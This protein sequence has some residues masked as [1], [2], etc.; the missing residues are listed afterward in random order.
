[1][2]VTTVNE[3]VTDSVITLTKICSAAAKNTYD[4]DVGY[5]G[6]NVTLSGNVLQ[7]AD[8]VAICSQNSNIQSAVKAEMMSKVKALS[9]SKDTN[10]LTGDVG[11]FNSAASKV[12]STNRALMKL[13]TQD[14]QHCITNAT[15]SY[16][17][18]M[19]EVQGNLEIDTFFNQT[20]NADITKCMLDAGVSQNLAFDMKQDI[21]ATAQRKGTLDTIMEKLVPILIAVGVAAVIVFGIVMYLRYRQSNAATTPTIVVTGPQRQAAAPLLTEADMRAGYIN[22]D[23]NSDM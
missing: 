18:K 3:I 12:N 16:T 13:S 21:D 15:N 14:T 6:G 2:S 7:Q 17:L 1:M 19:Q 20:A 8:A 11:F 22:V 10:L 23:T 5:V 4:L 9:Q